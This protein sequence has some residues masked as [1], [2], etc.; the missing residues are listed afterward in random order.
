VATKLN[1]GLVKVL[2]SPELKARM[3]DQGIDVAPSTQEE[4]LKFVKEETAKWKKVVK[5]AGLVETN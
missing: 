4:F 5:E 2:S 1:A 3:A